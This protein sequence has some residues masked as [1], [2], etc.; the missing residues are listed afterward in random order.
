[1]SAAQTHS[2]AWGGRRLLDALDVTDLDTFD[3]RPG[4]DATPTMTC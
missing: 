1:M 4:G 3:P 2:P